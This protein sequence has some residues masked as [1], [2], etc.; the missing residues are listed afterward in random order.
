MDSCSMPYHTM[1]GFNQF[2][3]QTPIIKNK[4][5]NQRLFCEQSDI[6]CSLFIETSECSLLLVILL[7]ILDVYHII[8]TL[9]SIYDVA[10]SAHPDDS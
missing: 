1:K 8:F 7:V 4:D 3:G 2:Q 6:I 10:T 9:G 5:S